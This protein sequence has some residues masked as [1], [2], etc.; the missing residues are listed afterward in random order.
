MH[1]PRDRKSQT[2]MLCLALSAAWG[3]SC[4]GA[5]PDRDP[6]GSHEMAG[7]AGD[8]T[9]PEAG[10]GGKGGAVTEG[11]EAHGGRLDGA[12]G[13]KDYGGDAGE[14]YAGSPSGGAGMSGDAGAGGDDGGGDPTACQVVYE[15]GHG[16]IFARYD[17]AGELRLRLRSHL[18]YPGPGGGAAE[19]EHDPEGIC[20]VVPY[21]SYLERQAAGGRPLLELD[22]TDRFEPLGVP[23]GEA[24]WYLSANNLGAEQPFF[25]VATEGVPAQGIFDGPLRFDFESFDMPEGASFSVYQVPWIPFFY[26]STS[27]P[28][29][30]VHG[31]QRIE[32]PPGGHDHYAWTFSHPGRYAI[33]TVVSGD[34]VS[35]GTV[36]SAP[37]TYIF[38]VEAQP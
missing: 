35:G 5:T 22:G 29:A 14:S 31:A 17:A 4:D 10:S 1:R 37:A 30:T 15:A 12:E 21:S 8:A 11:G 27:R 9:R 23:A 7:Q 34:R 13:G 36:A 32:M 6:N 3:A 20:I 2:V 25:G 24:Y 28:D 18:T 38:I 19:P 33:R 16:D 26:V